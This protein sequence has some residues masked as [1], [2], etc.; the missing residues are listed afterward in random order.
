MFGALSMLTVER[1]HLM[2]YF[3]ML[4]FL[5]AIRIQFDDAMHYLTRNCLASY[6][7]LRCL[8]SIKWCFPANDSDS[9]AMTKVFKL[10]PSSFAL[11]TRRKWIDFGTR[12]THLPL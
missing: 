4:L 10:T 2:L 9:I 11:L 7:F 1:R 5:I 8:E 12:C 6:F 3:Q